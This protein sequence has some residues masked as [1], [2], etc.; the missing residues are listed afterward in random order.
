MQTIVPAP[1]F[2]TQLAPAPALEP[3]F[4]EPVFRY[5]PAVCPECGGALEDVI[6]FGCHFLECEYSGSVHGS[7][8]CFFSFAVTGRANG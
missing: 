3:V 5:V 2:L 1:S 6:D 8:E 7:R 4:S